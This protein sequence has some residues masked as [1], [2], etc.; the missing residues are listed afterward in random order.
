M[1]YDEFKVPEFDLPD[2]QILEDSTPVTPLSPPPLRSKGGFKAL[3][4]KINF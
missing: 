1:N 3:P 2:P 4:P